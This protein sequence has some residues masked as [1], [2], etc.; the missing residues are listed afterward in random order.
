MNTIA[1]ALIY[2]VAYINLRASDDEDDG[3][4][5]AGALESIAAMLSSATE[6]ERDE[7]AAAVELALAQE[8]SGIPRDEFI[9]TYSTWMEDMF[10]EGWIGNKRG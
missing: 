9:Q 8:K 5:D 10:G 3:D 6:E 1:S 2:A 4:G 7:L